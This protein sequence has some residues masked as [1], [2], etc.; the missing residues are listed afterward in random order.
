MVTILDWWKGTLLQDYTRRATGM[1][2]KVPDQKD[3]FRSF[4][5]KMRE[6]PILSF[7]VNKN[8]IDIAIVFC[9]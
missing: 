8:K 6:I 4:C 3:P 5:P 7:A 9:A 2:S 1:H